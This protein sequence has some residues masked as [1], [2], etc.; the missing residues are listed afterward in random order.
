MPIYDLTLPISAHL[1]V[2]PGDPPV[3]IVRE[4]DAAQGDAFTLTRLNI[5]AHTGTHIDAPRHFFPSGLAID[6][7]PLDRLMGPAWV[8]EVEDGKD[9]KGRKAGEGGLV[10]AAGLEGLR[11]PVDVTRLL[12]KTANSHLWTHP[13]IPTFD[14][15]FVALDPSAARWLVER[16]IQLIGIDYLSIERGDESFPVHTALLR[17]GVVILEGLNLAH[18]P[19]GAYHLIAL[20]MKITDADGAPA[21]VVLIGDDAARL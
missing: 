11:I 16:G 6:Q 10:T 12:L 14:P 9:G 20:P 2:W 18:V 8:A 17:A 21:R 3:E 1:A 15:D 7:L 19:P 13:L 4:M 5:S